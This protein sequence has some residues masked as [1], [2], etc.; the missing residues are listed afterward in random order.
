MLNLHAIWTLIHHNKNNRMQQD[1]AIPLT[2]IQ[3]G[4]N[5]FAYTFKA[6]FEYS[7]I[8]FKKAISIKKNT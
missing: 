8:R 6:L 3:A 5:V 1:I 2:K 4:I 7:L